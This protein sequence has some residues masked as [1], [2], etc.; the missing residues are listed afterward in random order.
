M[1]GTDARDPDGVLEQDVA[2]GPERPDLPMPPPPLT[3]LPPP[4]PP[5][6][7]P[8]AG[9]PRRSGGLK[10]AAT[11][12]IAAVA[13]VAGGYGV[14]A[15]TGQGQAATPSTITAN[16]ASNDGTSTTSVAALAATAERSVV[17][18][19]SRITVQGSFFQA[20]QTGELVGTGFVIGSNGLVLT[21]A[22]VV[23]HAQSI[24]VT[25][26]NGQTYQATV[27]R[28]DQAGDLAELKI[29]AAG[30]PVLRL[31]TSSSVVGDPVVAIGYALGL[32]GDP[33]VTTGIVSSTDRTIQVQDD[34]AG[35]VRTYAHILQISAAI[36]SGNSGGPVLDADGRVIAI[37]TAGATGAQ[38]VGFA[39][40][41]AQA[42]S[43]IAGA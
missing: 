2:E 15:V 34:V 39:I 7:V 13:L 12:T 9:S 20:A 42:T 30:L 5:S 41:V 29:D 4:P 11:A 31:D 40:P 38:S 28:S 21:N 35:V 26:A 14:R 24:T 32:Q 6:P 16:A 25:M 22:H 36:N 37:A 1:D 3:P 8:A 10:R 33:T 27:V 19:T 23:E 18:I 43:L 17:R